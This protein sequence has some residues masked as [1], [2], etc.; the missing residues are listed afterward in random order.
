VQSLSDLSDK[1][2]RYAERTFTRAFEF[3][4]KLAEAKDVYD[5]TK[6][7]TEFVQSQVQAIYELVS[8]L[9]QTA[10]KAMTAGAAAPTQKT[11]RPKAVQPTVTLKQIARA[12]AGRHGTAK[13][14]M[15]KLLSATIAMTAGHLEKGDRV[16]IAGLGTFQ[17]RNRAARLGR[18]PATGEQIAI[19]ASKTVAFRAAKEVNEALSEG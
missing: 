6:L 2:L 19:K 18:N 4:Q 5:A 16:R 14:R 8:A 10:D 11:A 3:M 7:Q 17:V 15:D 9:G 13:K 1:F 12:L